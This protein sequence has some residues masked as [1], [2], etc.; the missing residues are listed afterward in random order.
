MASKIPIIYRGDDTNFNDDSRLSVSVNSE[1]PL[2]G[3]KVEV[4]FQG[5][6][7]LFKNIQNGI[8]FHFSYTARQTASFAVGAYK[9]TIRLRDAKGRVCTLPPKLCIVTDKASVA[10]E[11]RRSVAEGEASVNAL[12]ESDIFD[13]GVTLIDLKERIA[14]LWERLGGTASTLQMENIIDVKKVMLQ[15]WK[16]YGGTV[17]NEPKLNPPT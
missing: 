9:M 14:Y 1:V 4:I 13:C 5:L 16:R 15:L 12:S 8:P 10:A 2:D 11:W 3:M 7:K 17:T 6:R